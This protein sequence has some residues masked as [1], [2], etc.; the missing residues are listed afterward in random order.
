MKGVVVVVRLLLSLRRT[1]QL[2]WR[3]RSIRY[4]RNEV[5]LDRYIT[6]RLPFEKINEAFHLL[7]EGE[8]LRAV[9]Y[10]G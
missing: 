1:F 9:L 5:T 3:R 2:T 7:H 8:C 6:H 10:W 4:M